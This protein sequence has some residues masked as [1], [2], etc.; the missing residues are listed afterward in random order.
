[1]WCIVP[2]T[3]DRSSLSISLSISLRQLNPTLSLKNPAMLSI[4]LDVRVLKEAFEKRLLSFALNNCSDFNLEGT[5]LLACNY[6]ET[7][8]FHSKHFRM[9]H[10]FENVI[11]YENNAVLED[12]NVCRAIEPPAQ[13]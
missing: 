2:S 7:T 3:W 9:Q 5:F 4:A 10:R 8:L 13:A 1:M 11:G 6:S 12:G